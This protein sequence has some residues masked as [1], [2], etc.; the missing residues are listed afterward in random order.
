M[1][2]DVVLMHVVKMV[3]VKIVHMAVMAN[4]PLRPGNDAAILASHLFSLTPGRFFGSWV[5]AMRLLDFL[6]MGS[7]WVFGRGVLG[8][9][10]FTHLR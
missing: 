9:F 7:R 6:S 8:A 1:F 4:F 3:V 5:L 2:I 10:T